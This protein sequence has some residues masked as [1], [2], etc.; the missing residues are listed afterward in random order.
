M[1][2]HKEAK[3]AYLANPRTG[4]TATAEALMKIGFKKVGTHHSGHPSSSWAYVTF[5]AVRNHWDAAVSWVFGRHLGQYKDLKFTVETIEFALNNEFISAD[6]MWGYHEPRLTMR[7]ERPTDLG[8]VLATAELRI[9]RL[10]QRN[11]S[12][13]RKRR[14]YREFHTDKTKDYI[15]NRFKTEILRLGYEY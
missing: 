6:K 8:C 13:V 10:P 2:L 9:D 3:L 11:V 5:A 12:D 15:Y 14:H 7:Y 1:Y 4:S